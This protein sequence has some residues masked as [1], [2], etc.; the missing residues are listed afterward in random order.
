MNDSNQLIT[1]KEARKLLGRTA[2]GKTDVEVEDIIIQLDF[3][4]TQA[5]RDFKRSQNSQKKEGS[6]ISDGLLLRNE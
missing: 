6:K 5:I 3:I 1:I 4:A 2:D